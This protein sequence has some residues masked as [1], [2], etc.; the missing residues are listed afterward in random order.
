MPRNYAIDLLRGLVM[1]IMTLDHVRDFFHETALTAS[2]TDLNTTTPGLFWTRVITHLCAPTFVFLILLDFTLI[3][4]GL[5]WDIRFQ[6]LLFNVLAAIGTGFIGLA[7]LHKLP[8]RDVLGIGLLITFAYPLLPGSLGGLINPAVYP[9]GPKTLIVG[10]PPL[11]WL[12]ILLLGYSLKPYL[13]RTF[14]LKAGAFLLLSFFVLRYF[15]L[16]G[17]TNPWQDLLSF[18]NLSKYPP[19]PLFSLLTLGI[20]FFLLGALYKK[21]LPALITF[22]RVPLFYFITHWYLIHFLLFAYLLA[23]GFGPDT[24]EGGQNLGRPTAWT[25]LDLSGVYLAWALTVAGMYP[26]CRWYLHYKRRH[27]KST[28]T[29]YV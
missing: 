11:P 13:N 5:F 1:V 9:V 4:F 14:S 3:A 8:S 28:L 21:E 2:P 22:G 17:E 16:Y 19:S 26:L 12:G 6:T 25:G 15:N 20:M 24:W 10:Y 29:K 7:L 18:F 23:Q 27:P